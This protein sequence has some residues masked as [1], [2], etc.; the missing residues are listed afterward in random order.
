MVV[1][2]EKCRLRDG[3]G[4]VG[5]GE[6]VGVPHTANA[7]LKGGGRRAP[8]EVLTD[9]LGSDQHKNRRPSQLH[10]SCSATWRPAPPTAG[11]GRRPRRSPLTFP[12]GEEPPATQPPFCASNSSSETQAADERGPVPFSSLTPLRR[13]SAPRWRQRARRPPAPCRRRKV[14]EGGT[15]GKRSR[16]TPR[17]LTSPHLTTAG[18]GRRWPASLGAPPCGWCGTP[19]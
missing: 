4:G 9:R 19:S 14:L 8:A 12:W 6:R 10:L 15:G 2:N 11:P 7:A 5:T 3:E 18:C 13:E 17:R 16:L 1:N